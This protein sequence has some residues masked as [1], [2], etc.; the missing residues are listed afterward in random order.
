MHSFPQQSS[1]STTS[2]RVANFIYTVSR[3]KSMSLHACYFTTESTQL[4]HH[5]E[6]AE[7]HGE[8]NRS[9]LPQKQVT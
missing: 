4:I 9:P 7:N 6:T 3:L 5:E 8:S 1:E 2:L